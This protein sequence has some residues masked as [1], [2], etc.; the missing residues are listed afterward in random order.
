MEKT[1]QADGTTPLRQTLATE[2]DSAVPGYL[3]NA[4]WWAYLHPRA[5]RFFERQWLVNLILWGNFNRL[6]DAS[7]DDLGAT[8]QGRT[9]QVAC[10]YG[11]FTGKLAARLGPDAQLDVVDVA[12]VQLQNT[13][14]K[15]GEPANVIL[16]RQDSAQLRFPDASFDNTVVFF[17]LHEQPEAVRRATIEQAIRVTRKGGRLVFVDYHRPG[18]WNP[19]RYLMSG[20]F[21]LLEPFA[22]DFWSREIEDWAGPKFQP[23]RVTKQTYFGGMYQK[24]TFR[25]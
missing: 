4:Y 16:H 22:E 1:P 23:G 9:L 19:M 2:P 21:K 7:L 8:V 10:V 3:Q 12:Q 11:D 14:R 6:R 5:V 24:T 17:L 20:V 25:L 18:R 13:R 15:I